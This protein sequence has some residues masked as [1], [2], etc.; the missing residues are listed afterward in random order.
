MAQLT[1][2]GEVTGIH[3]VT[4][5]DVRRGTL[6]N[7]GVREDSEVER[8][9]RFGEEA[10]PLPMSIVV[11]ENEEL[12]ISHGDRV[13]VAG[14]TSVRQGTTYAFISA[15]TTMNGVKVTHKAAPADDADDNADAAAPTDAKG[16]P[17]PF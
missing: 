3:Q 13:E 4:N 1:A 6:W 17:I 7:F 11:P 16:D 10:I 5:V 2:R 14:Y 9:A 15:R 12:P 8:A